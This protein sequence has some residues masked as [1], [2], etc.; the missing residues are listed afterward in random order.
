MHFSLI[1]LLYAERRLDQAMRYARFLATHTAPARCVF[2]INGDQVTESAV[3]ARWQ[4]ALPA[5]ILFHDNTGAEFGGYQ[6][7]FRHLGSALPDRLIVMNDTLGSHDL[8]TEAMLAGFVRR[9]GFE[10]ERFVVGKVDIAHRRLALDGL[11]ATRWV[12]SHLMGFDR[13]A[14]E[15][16][17]GRLYYPHLDR[18]IRPVGAEESFFDPGVGEHLRDL[19]RRFLFMSGPWSWYGAQPLSE[20]NAAAMAIKAR[21]ILQEKY[22]SMKLE[23]VEAAFWDPAL[24]LGDE[25]RHRRSQA[26]AFVARRFRSLAQT[27]GGSR[28]RSS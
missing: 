8:M 11:W 14:L 26:I 4:V 15:A 2:V 5:E 10:L 20:A 21:A 25:I 7:G 6:A 17:G 3:R 13:A 12:R 24:S 1:V 22:L 18:L 23:E 9:L 16:I 28:S 19:I 27:R